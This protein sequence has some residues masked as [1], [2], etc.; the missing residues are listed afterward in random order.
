MT[1][2]LPA[3]SSSFSV[4]GFLFLDPGGLPF[5]RHFVFQCISRALGTLCCG[6]SAASGVSMGAKR[7]GPVVLTAS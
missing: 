5:F 6:N 1:D 2:L 7:E 4:C 3:A